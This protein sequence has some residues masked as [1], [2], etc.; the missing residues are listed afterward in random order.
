LLDPG[1]ARSRRVAARPPR[2]AQRALAIGSIEVWDSRT[3]AYAFAVEPDNASAALRS[4]AV[5]Q[6]LRRGLG[7]ATTATKVEDLVRHRLSAQATEEGRS[8]GML[9]MQTV[10]AIDPLAPLCWRGTVLWPDG[11]GPLLAAAPGDP[12]SAG[13]LEDLIAVEAIT[14]WAMLRPER[15]DYPM[16]RLEA[17]QNRAWLSTRGA[18]GGLPRLTYLLNPLLPCASPLVADRWIARL[19]D[20]PAALDA[21]AAANPKPVPLD[22]QLAAFIAARGDS[23]LESDANALAG[24]AQNPVGL[25]ELRLLAQLQVRHYARPLP[26]LA[27]WMAGASGSMVGVWYNRP[28]RQELVERLRSL[29][30][31]GMLMPMLVLVE[32]PAGRNA[33]AGGARLAVADLNRIDAELQGIAAA[34]GERKHAAERIGQEIA[35]GVGLVAL[36]AMLALAALV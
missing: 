9:L 29:A 28:R 6:W 8:D 7:D 20:L 24:T 1:V 15:C 33:D 26:A 16:L 27:A 32:D 17:R 4:G 12:S 19:A 34:A 11:L 35:A 10:T 14:T 25:P 21:A 18:A 5:V 22:A 2:K 3:L 23:R 31:T 36:A 13:A 30:E